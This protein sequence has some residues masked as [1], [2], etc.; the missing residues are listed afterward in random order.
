MHDTAQDLQAMAHVI[1]RYGL[2]TGTQ[3]AA[4]GPS[5]PMDICAVAYTVAERCAPPAEFY[6]D[7]VTSLAIIG[8]SA[9]AMAAIRAISDALDSSVCETE[10]EPGTW[11]PDYIEHVSNW[12]ATAS[13][14]EPKRP[15]TI[16]EVI[17]RILRA[18]NNLATRTLETRYGRTDADGLCLTCRGHGSL[19]VDG[20]EFPYE[21]LSPRRKQG[22]DLGHRFYRNTFKPCPDCDGQDRVTDAAVSAYEA[23][24]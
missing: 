17:G 11:F 1:A 9:P 3:F 7:E 20:L 15:P 19:M 21:E 16:D 2:H 12:A 10:R 23:S 6:T 5:A 22:H 24:L 13:P 8:A 18:A 4:P 14:V